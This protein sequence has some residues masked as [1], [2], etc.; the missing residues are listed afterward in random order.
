MLNFKWEKI[1]K[2][3]LNELEE[4]I[5]SIFPEKN[6]HQFGETPNDFIAL[7][8]TKVVR[9][10]EEYGWDLF[11]EALNSLENKKLIYWENINQGVNVIRKTKIIS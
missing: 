6:T 2:N 3:K 1:M 8:F 10:R 9:L 5:L 4:K 7:N 11:D